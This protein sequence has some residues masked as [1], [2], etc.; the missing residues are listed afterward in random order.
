MTRGES[1][2]IWALVAVIGGLAAL[3]GL[4]LLFVRYRRGEI[5]GRYFGAVVAGLSS[6]AT[7]ALISAFRPELATGAT[8]LI[9]LFP[10][11][12]AIVVLLRERGTA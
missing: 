8:S 6:L 7:Y 5:T 4:A 2:G 9:V 12:V 11:F 3:T 10:A 1:V